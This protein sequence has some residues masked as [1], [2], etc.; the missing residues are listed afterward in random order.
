MDYG[1]YA[2]NKLKSQFV[3]SPISS[4]FC[5]NLRKAFQNPTEKKI[6]R[7][8]GVTQFQVSLMKKYTFPN[9]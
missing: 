3:N 5:Q 1:V 2:K 8:W 7:K 9:Q 6:R 4:Y